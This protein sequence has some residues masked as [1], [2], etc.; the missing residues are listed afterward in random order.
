M[1]VNGHA[2]VEYLGVESFLELCATQMRGAL[3]G[4]FPVADVRSPSEFVQGHIPGAVNIPLFSDAERA[5]V[6]TLHKRESPEAAAI[7]GLEIAGPKLGDLVRAAY[8]LCRGRT[9]GEMALYCDRGRMRSSSVGWVL[10]M[11]GLRVRLLEGG[12]KAFRHHVLA[13]FERPLNLLVLG[14]KTGSGKTLV[15]RRMSAKG[16]QMVDLEGLANH[17]GSAFGAL[18]GR[19]QPSCE[20]F[21]NS[22]SVALSRMRPDVPVWVEDECENLGTVNLPRAFFRQLKASPLLTLEVPDHIRLE[23]VLEDYAS[24]PR[25][26]IAQRLDHIK[27]RLGGLEH[28]RAH[29]CLSAGDLPGLAAILLTYYDRAYARQCLQRPPAAVVRTGD[30]EEA[31]IRLL[32]LGF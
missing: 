32:E 8:A 29:A 4:P 27:K 9:G 17:R 25:D 6:G 3:P 30:P 14:G 2:N 18:A 19:P 31:A 1:I 5:E 26:Y 13:S 7:R 20:Q 12:Y 16:A 24:L 22:L 28:S 10:T 11:A 23:R 15:L 21:E